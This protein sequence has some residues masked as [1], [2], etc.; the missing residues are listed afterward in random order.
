MEQFTVLLRTSQRDIGTVPLSSFL[1]DVVVRLYVVI[2]NSNCIPN[3]CIFYRSFEV[4]SLHPPSV[5]VDRRQ[6]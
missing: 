5:T 4:L 2:V 1:L 6:L 3:S